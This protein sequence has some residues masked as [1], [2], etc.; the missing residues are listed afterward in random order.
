MSDAQDGAAGATDPAP[1][2]EEPT[3]T[4]ATIL[5]EVRDTAPTAEREQIA[6]MIRERLQRAGVELPDAEVEQLTTQI[7]DGHA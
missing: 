1:P 4:V 5:A 2:V 6:E 7:V 3:A